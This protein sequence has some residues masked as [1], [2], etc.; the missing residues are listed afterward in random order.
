MYGL[1]REYATEYKTEWERIDDNERIYQGDH[2]RV[3]DDRFLGGDARIPR[4]STPIVTSTIENIKADLS[5]EFPE[6]M[7]VPEVPDNEVAQCP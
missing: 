5:D 6:A 4:P 3:E 7:I 1:F 2:W